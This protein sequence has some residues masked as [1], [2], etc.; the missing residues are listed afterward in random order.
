MKMNYKILYPNQIEIDEGAYSG[1]FVVAKAKK[2]LAK[3]TVYGI[4]D[5]SGALYWTR[6]QR[7]LKSGYKFR[8]LRRVIISSSDNLE[9]TY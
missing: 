7:N 8:P 5:R 6:L 4:I 3:K 9:Y 2:T 1:I